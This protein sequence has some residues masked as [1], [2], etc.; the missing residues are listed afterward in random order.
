MTRG[1]LLRTHV[2][3]VDT[4][5]TYVQCVEVSSLIRSQNGI[6]F[7]PVRVGRG[8]ELLIIRIIIIMVVSFFF[9]L[10]SLLLLLR[11]AVAPV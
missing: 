8:V 11:K 3:N 5:G 4:S 10:S 7:I 9:P 2:C 1:D 6:E